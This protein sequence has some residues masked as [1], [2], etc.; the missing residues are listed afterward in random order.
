MNITV[1]QLVD[2]INAS[3]REITM[4]INS[5]CYYA[6]THDTET[7]TAMIIDPDKLIEALRELE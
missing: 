1:A 2:A 7:T 4:L 6:S 5:T 3:K